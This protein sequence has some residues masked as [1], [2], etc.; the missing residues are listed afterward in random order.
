[1][2]VE[3]CSP[4]LHC[5]INTSLSQSFPKPL[6]FLPILFSLAMAAHGG[7][8]NIV[9]RRVIDDLIDISGER[10][11]PKYLKIFIE[12][13]IT[14][15]RGFIARMR[16]EIRTSMNLIRWQGGDEQDKVVD[17]NRLIDVIEEKIHGKE[18]DLEM[19]EAEDNDGD[20]VREH[21]GL[22]ILSRKKVDSEARDKL[23]DEITRYFDVDLTVK[24]LVK[25]V[26]AKMAR[27][28][29]VYQHTMG[30]GGYALKETADKIKEETL[31]VDHGTDAMTVVLG[32]EN[33]LDNERH[34]RQ[35]KELLI[36]NLSNKMSQTEGMVS[37][38]DI[39]PINSSADEEGGTTVVGCENDASIQKSNGLATLEK[40]METRVSNKTSPDET[41]KS[42]RSKKMTRSIRQDSSRQ[43]SQSQENV[44]PLLVLPQKSTIISLG[45]VYKT[46]GKQMLHN[47]ELPKD[48]YKVSIDTSLVDAACIPDVRNNGFKTVKDAVGGFFAWPKD[49]VVFDPKAT[50]PST[51]QMNI[52]NKA[53]PKLQTKCKNVYVSSDAMQ[54]QAKKKSLQ[55]SLNY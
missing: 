31:K 20:M 4:V 38:V 54:R 13:Q 44:S 48:C 29:S 8:N 16:D 7:R 30:R 5:A 9:A 39:N 25:S 6:Q 49:Q 55:K 50:P 42:A 45:I 10:S 17:F 40:E 43:D 51:I 28:K 37:P 18:I 23:W 22:K 41:V 2:M 53:A 36:Q 33:Q 15:H 21:I 1:M 19:L 27:S 3:L 32:K 52:E 11:P 26:A 35:E 47:K 24:K 46:D 34:E 12:Q 14:D